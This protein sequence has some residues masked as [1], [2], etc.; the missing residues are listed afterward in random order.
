MSDILKI[1]ENISLLPLPA[2]SPHLNPTESILHEL[3]E[4]WFYNRYFD[5]LVC[6]EDRLFEALIAI[7]NDSVSVKSILALIGLLA[8]FRLLSSIISNFNSFSMG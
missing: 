4:K 5:S 2:H 3:R 1:P 8:L 6:V 7:E